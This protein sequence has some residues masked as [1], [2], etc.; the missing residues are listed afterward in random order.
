[1][2]DWSPV[3]AI[4]AR[5]GNHESL[6]RQLSGAHPKLAVYRKGELPAR[7][8]FGTHPRVTP[9]VGVAA[10]GWTIASRDRLPAI[11]SR[12]SYGDHGY[13]NALPSMHGLFVAG[14]PAFQRGLRVPEVDSIHLYELMAAILG[15]EPAPNE[16]DL[17]AVRDLLRI[18]VASR[19]TAR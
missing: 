9:I 11:R 13:D 3:L 1:V 7:W 5:D 17:G 16:G 2:Q 8:R 4:R 15:L 10:E 19:T 18:D 12:P 6:Y 14:G